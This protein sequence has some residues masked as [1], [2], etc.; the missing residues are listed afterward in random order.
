[1]LRFSLMPIRCVAQRDKY[2]C[3]GAE[4]IG[5]PRLMPRI[6]KMIPRT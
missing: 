6:G 3:I 4:R 5:A 2:I 1:M